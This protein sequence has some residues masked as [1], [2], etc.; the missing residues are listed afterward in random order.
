MFED[1]IRKLDQQAPHRTLDGLEASIWTGVA[2]HTEAIWHARLVFSC[3]A[4][5][6]ALGLILSV[7]AGT[8]TAA[9]DSASKLVAFAAT[10]DLAPSSRLLGR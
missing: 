9:Q 5:V 10:P 6:L 7:A 3:Q 2:A 8:F 1:D 4:T